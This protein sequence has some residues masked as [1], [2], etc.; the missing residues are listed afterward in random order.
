MKNVFKMVG[1]MICFVFGLLLA[2]LYKDLVSLTGNAGF[3]L[4]TLGGVMSALSSIILL[5]ATFK[6]IK[7]RVMIR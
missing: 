5:V 2:V 4:A 3:V 6:G 7:H 1:L